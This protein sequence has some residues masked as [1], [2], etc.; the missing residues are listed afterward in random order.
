[1]VDISR[2][3]FVAASAGLAAGCATG[4]GLTPVPGGDYAAAVGAFEHGD[5]ARTSLFGVVDAFRYA[6]QEPQALPMREATGLW[7]AA[8]D[9]A[10]RGFALHGVLGVDAD[11]PK[12]TLFN[13]DTVTAERRVDLPLPAG[14]VWNYPGGLA[15][16]ANGYVYVA[17]TTRLAKLDPETLAVRAIVDLPAPNGLAGTCYNGFIILPGGAILAKSH[18]RKV[19]CPDQ[20]FRALVTCGIEGLPASSLV[21]IDPDTL[22]ILWQGYAPELI[23]GRITSTVFASRQYIYLA[24]MNDIHRM[25]YERGHIRADQDWHPVPYRQGDETPGTAVVGFGDHVVV[26]SNALPTRAP[27]RITVIHQ[28]APDRVISAQPFASE[29][30]TQSFMP[31]KASTDLVNGRIYCGDAHGGIA[32]LRLQSGALVTDWTAPIKTGSFLT[33]IGPQQRR[34]LVASD[35]GDASYDTF[36]APTH[37]TETCRWLDAAT[38]ATLAAVENLPRNFG[39]TLVPKADGSIFYPTRTQGLYR[40]RPGRPS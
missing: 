25:V 19:D 40:L 21:L 1:M 30:A 37:R 35:I 26:Q 33:I 16:H 3:A 4:A 27:L 15:V 34:I 22:Q 8:F 29:G 24:G 2:R 38:G 36:G 9:A 28:A 7:S 12:V 6:G 39:L 5:S 14:P 20:G 11:T 17:Y 13:P 10:G 32:A 18:H 31:S 23:G